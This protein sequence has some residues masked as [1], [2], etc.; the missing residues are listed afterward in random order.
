MKEK[1]LKIDCGH[2]LI[3]YVEKEDHSYGPLQTG[4]LMAGKY[5]DDYF[6]KKD[7]LK[8]KRLGELVEGNISPLAYYKDLVDIGEGDLAIR[9]GVSRRKLRFHMTPEGFARL[10]VTLLEKYAEVFG[11]P[12]AQLFQ[13]V[14]CDDEQIEVK[15]QQTGLSQVI[16]SKISNTGNI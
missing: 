2:Q 13:I 7:K 14:L 10:T 1:D 6:E 8:Q 16:I 4:S 15:Y 11:I 5:L 9:V 12:V 3:L